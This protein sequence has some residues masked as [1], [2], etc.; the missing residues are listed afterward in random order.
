MIVRPFIRG[1]LS[2]MPGGNR[3]L[4]RRGTGGTD[5]ALYCYEVWMKHLAFLRA[6]GIDSVPGTLAELGPGDSIGVGLAALLSGVNRYYALDML[7]YS[8]AHANEKILDELV[9]LFSK[10]AGRPCGSWPDYTPWLDERLFPS[11]ILTERSLEASLSDERLRR[12]RKALLHPESDSGEIAIRY[13]V[14]WTDEGAVEAGTVDMIVSQAVLEHVDDLEGAYRAFAR[15]LK[16]GGIMSHQISFHSHGLSKRWNG[17]RAYPEIVW[18][19]LRGRRPWLLN[20]QPPSVHIELARSNGF[21]ILRLD[22]KRGED[23][24]ARSELAARWRQLSDDDL[25]CIDIFM[26]AR[27][28]AG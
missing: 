26:Q 23:G 8:N 3:M 25:A 15:W 18:T 9:A 10:R 24:I 14:P 6:S 11:A 1:I 2:F 21:T 16:P 7:R 4:P 19:L 12:I 27:K 22:T 20:R 5:S 13:V 17:Y 28:R